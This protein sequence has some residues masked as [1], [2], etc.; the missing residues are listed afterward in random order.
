MN[1]ER[2]TMLLAA[3]ARELGENPAAMLVAGR[4][5]PQGYELTILIVRDESEDESEVRAKVERMFSDGE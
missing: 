1:E 3:L 4:E 2:I 5:C